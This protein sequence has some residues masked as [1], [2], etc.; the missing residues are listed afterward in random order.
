MATPKWQCSA[1]GN[2][3]QSANRPAPRANGKCSDTSSGNHK[4]EKLDD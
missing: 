4:W 1:C 2:M 3:Y